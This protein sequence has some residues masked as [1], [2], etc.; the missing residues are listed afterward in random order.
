MKKYLI[1]FAILL[2]LFLI[3]SCEDNEHS[4]VRCGIC[5]RE[6]QAGDAGGNFMNITWSGFCKSC[7]KGY[8]SLN[9]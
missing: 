4:S 8:H 3:G 2:G 7:E 1:I 5:G 6:Y 9:Q